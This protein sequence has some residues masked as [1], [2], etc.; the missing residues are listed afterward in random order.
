MLVVKCKDTTSIGYQSC[1]DTMNDSWFCTNCKFFIS[2]ILSIFWTVVNFFSI[3]T[4]FCVE[5]PVY[6]SDHFLH[7]KKLTNRKRTRDDWVTL[8]WRHIY[9]LLPILFV[10][11]LLIILNGKRIFVARDDTD[12]KV[13]DSNYYYILIINTT[14]HQ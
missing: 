6:Y 3:F 9:D 12:R 2:Y 10:Q 1:W 13:L 14:R 11:T 7:Q 4:T 5:R 8:L